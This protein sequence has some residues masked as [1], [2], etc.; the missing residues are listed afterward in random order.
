MGSEVEWPKEKGPLPIALQAVGCDE[1]AAFEIVRNG[2]VIVREE[3][4]GVF[5]QALLE[6]T[7]P[8]SGESWYYA[9]IL[10]KDR[11]MAWSS[12]V[13]VKR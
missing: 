7:N 11:N 13:W 1:I 9:R 12:P 3:G 6:D 5:A 2:E 8:P 4:K 10:Q